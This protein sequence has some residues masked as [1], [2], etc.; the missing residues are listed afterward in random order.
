MG[1]SNKTKV[2]LMLRG[3]A[4]TVF[5]PKRPVAYSV[6]GA[7]EEEIQRLLSLGILKP[8]DHSDWAA[9]IVAVR[10]PNGQIRICADFSTDLYNVLEP[11]QYPLPLPEDIFT[12]MAGCI[13]FSHLDL[14]NVYLQVAV[15][16]QSQHLLTI[17]TYK[18]LFQYTRLTP[19][20]K[21]VLFSS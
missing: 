9:P 17:N 5:R 1:I 19:G 20:I 6:Q 7:V 14:S 3:D 16:Q 4:K 13:I 18:G 15:D 12:K 10:K 11:N 2:Q 8:V 21:G